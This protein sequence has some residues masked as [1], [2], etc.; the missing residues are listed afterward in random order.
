[1]IKNENKN[2]NISNKLRANLSLSCLP[3]SRTFK[4]QSVNHTVNRCQSLSQST[5]FFYSASTARTT[6]SVTVTQ[7][8]G[9]GYSIININ[10]ITSG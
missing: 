5:K 1:M 2:D 4:Q 9:S 7:L 10:I 8:M 3:V 6:K